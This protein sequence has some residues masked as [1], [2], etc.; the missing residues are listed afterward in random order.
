MTTNSHA[1]RQVNFCTLKDWGGECQYLPLITLTCVDIPA[2]LYVPIS[3]HISE[4]ELS[5]H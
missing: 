4:T 2:P 5:A 3:I 1:T